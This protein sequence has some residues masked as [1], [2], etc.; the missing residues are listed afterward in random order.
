MLYLCVYVHCIYT[1]HMHDFGKTLFYEYMLY[2][3]LYTLESTHIYTHTR[4]RMYLCLYILL[5]KATQ[6]SDN[7]A[8]KLSEAIWGGYGQ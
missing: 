3:Y 1:L 5:A 8:S 4:T 2:I 6:Q 7:C